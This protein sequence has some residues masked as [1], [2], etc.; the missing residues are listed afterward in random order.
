MVRILAFFTLI[1]SASFNAQILIPA[2]E[3]TLEHKQEFY[4]NLNVDYFSTSIS[5]AVSKKFYRG[6]DISDLAIADSYNQHKNVN[7]FGLLINSEL[8]YR[9]G[10]IHLD[11]ANK[12]GLILRTGAYGYA[13]ASYSK[14]LFGTIFQGTKQYI[15]KTADYSGSSFDAGSFQKIGGGI[16]NKI[17]KTSFCLNIVH[18]SNYASAFV[19]EASLT[20]AVDSTNIN[21]VVDGTYSQKLK[22]KVPSM[23]ASVDIDIRLPIEWGK[24]NQRA[25]VQLYAS[26]LG[27]AVPT[28]VNQYSIDSSYIYNGLTFNQLLD[29]SL[30]KKDGAAW[31]DSLG[32]TYHRNAKV[33]ALPALIQFAKIV[34]ANSL[35]KFQLFCGIRIMPTIS[36]VPNVFAGIHWRPLKIWSTGFQASYG[37]FGGYRSGLYSNLHLK[38]LTV[39]LG[40]ENLYG[41]IS[42]NAHGQSIVF[43]A[44]LKL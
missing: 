13:S 3:D 11:K 32:I 9:N 37:G 44:A 41:L 6:G 31:L 1:I 42:K 5:N 36:F 2:M 12:W 39:S 10:A 33:V 16:Y 27:F 20:Q 22:S 18:M 35:Q 15:G 29:S 43:K 4:I 40:S 30:L 26:N 21:L 34:D 28:V 23:G 19:R 14:E 24:T 7:I 25:W 17:T 38:K 8:E